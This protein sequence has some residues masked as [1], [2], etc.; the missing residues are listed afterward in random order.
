MNAR[1]LSSIDPTVA[2]T[3]LS[4]G[5]QPDQAVLCNLSFEAP[6]HTLTG[7]EGPSGS[8]KSTLLLAIAGVI[9]VTG[10]VRLRGSELPASDGA[11]AELRLRTFGFVFQRGELLPELT[12][13][14][15]VALPL[16]LLGATRR[17]AER[18]AMESLE[19][20]GI[21]HCADRRPSH[22]SGGQAQRAS[23]ARALVHSPQIVLADEPT[24]SLD[25]VNREVVTG[26]LVGAAAAG[27]CVIAA[28]HDAELLAA[29]A[30]R[31]SMADMQT[32]DGSDLS[33]SDS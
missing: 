26:A 31:S 27:A 24:S 13:V 19:H 10:S 1:C 11:R 21:A 6:A 2:V 28:T 29:C 9:R 5:Y 23:V 12:V 8:G 4:F 22:V 25:S 14:E 7:I 32:I 33:A 17:E 18:T 3:Q 16:R 30:S 20:F 15:N